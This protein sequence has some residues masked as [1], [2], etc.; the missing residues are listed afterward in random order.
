MTLHE[1]LNTIKVHEEAIKK[2]SSHVMMDLDPWR[3]PSVGEV[4]EEAHEASCLM[5]KLITWSLSPQVG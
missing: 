5:K 1:A 4:V 2:N 3:S